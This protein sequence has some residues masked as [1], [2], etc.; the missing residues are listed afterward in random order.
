[1]AMTLG[2]VLFHVTGK[3]SA[4]LR[5]VLSCNQAWYRRFVFIIL[6]LCFFGSRAVQ[7]PRRPAWTPPFVGAA[8]ESLALV[9]TLWQLCNG[10]DLH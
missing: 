1:M 2:F 7:P 8:E 10:W 4:N 9:S 5:F 3:P 6:F